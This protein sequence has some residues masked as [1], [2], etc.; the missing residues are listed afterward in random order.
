VDNDTRIEHMICDCCGRVSSRLENHHTFLRRDKRFAQYVN[1]QKN[2][3]RVCPECHGTGATGG[4][5]ANNRRF[6]EKHWE[7]QCK[8]Y[9]QDTMRKWYNSVPIKIRE[10]YW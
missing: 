6:K 4:G 7:R 1:D 10:R 3:S 8:R 5:Q 9:G 2:M